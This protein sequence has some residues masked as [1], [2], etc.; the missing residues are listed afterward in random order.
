MDSKQYEQFVNDCLV[1]FE[2]KQGM[3]AETVLPFAREIDLEQRTIRFFQ[4]KELVFEAAIIPIG[5]WG[6]QSMTWV[7]AWA[8]PALDSSIRTE[9]EVLQE[10]QKITGNKDFL[11]KGPISADETKAWGL[12]A[13]ACRHLDGIGAYRESSGSSHWFFLVREIRHFQSPEV[14]LKKAQSTAEYFLKGGGSE[15]DKVDLNDFRTEPIELRPRIV[16]PAAKMINILRKRFPEIRFALPGVDL[17]GNAL[18]WAH[19]L[20]LQ[21]MFD[22]GYA[23]THK[24]YNLGG[25]NLSNSRFDEAIM[26]GLTLCDASLEN[27]SLVN[28]DLSGAD[29]RGVSFRKSFLNGVNFTRAALAGAD[30][31]GAELSRTLLTDVDLSEVKGLDEVRHLA[32]SEISLSTLIAS[33]FEITPTFL[34]KAGVSRGLI[35]D[36]VKG[37]RLSKIYQ[38]CFLSYSSKDKVFAGQLYNSLINAGVRVFW[39]H[40]DVVPGEY[41]A[42]Q[43]MEAINE[44]DRL[45]VILS[46]QSMASK[47]VAKEIELAWFHKRESLVAVRLCPIEDIRKWTKEQANLPDLAEVFPILD[48]SG[49]KDPADYDHAFTVLLKSFSGGV[50]F[51]H[52][53]STNSKT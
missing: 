35:E 52:V 15:N 10:L 47:W 44:H 16:S 20:H 25:A 49:W 30:F 50:D 18:P 4:E 12:T 39:D 27:C 43:I 23:A 22:W 37:K 7:W 5:S 46:A 3:I 53:S 51:R 42:D 34:H 28:V 19:D 48:F 31:T 11:S 17:R 41:L 40:F 1:E 2:A 6:S 45:L 26:R 29:L 14:L 24:S 38:T 32:P 13:I 9:S 36:L 8:N 21:M 33:R